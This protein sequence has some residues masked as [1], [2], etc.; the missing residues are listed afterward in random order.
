ML[1][2]CI[3]RANQ[4]ACAPVEMSKTGGNASIYCTSFIVTA[5][6]DQHAVAQTNE[7]KTCPVVRSTTQASLEDLIEKTETQ[8]GSK[9]QQDGV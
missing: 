7:M 2:I 4:Q 8:I 9:E 3:S 1:S 5:Q 6:P